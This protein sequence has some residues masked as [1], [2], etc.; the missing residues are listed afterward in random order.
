MQHFG[1]W[2]SGNN[3]SKPLTTLWGQNWLVHHY[4]L[5]WT[6]PGCDL[7]ARHKQNAHSV[8]ASIAASYV[9]G[10]GQS[11]LIMYRPVYR[12]HG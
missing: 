3:L 10:V 11:D 5:S 9:I 8:K 6:Y 12:N 4:C 1:V 7:S 2:Q